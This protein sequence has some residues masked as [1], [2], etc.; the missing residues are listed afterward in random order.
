MLEL[1][2]LYD[3]GYVEKLKS[4]LSGA[5]IAIPGSVENALAAFGLDKYK[6][7]R[8][9]IDGTSVYAVDEAGK[10]RDLAT[11]SDGEQAMFNMLLMTALG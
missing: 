11:L 8:V 7:R 4:R 10:E 9:R 3:V 5:G 6:W 2:R 1:Y